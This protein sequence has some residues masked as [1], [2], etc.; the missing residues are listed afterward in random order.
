MADLSGAWLGTYWHDGEPTRFEMTLVQGGNTLSG[1]I[2]DDGPLGEATLSGE[3]VGRTTH[4]TKRYLVSPVKTYP[5]QYEGQVSE[6]GNLIQGGWMMEAIDSGNWE[7]QRMGE[8]LTL[9]LETRQEV[10][11][12]AGRK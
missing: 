7:A 6:D 4:F 3:A 8:N 10:P 2:L 9:K 5:I 11:L 1:Y 12:A